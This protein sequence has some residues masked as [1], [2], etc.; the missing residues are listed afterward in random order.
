VRMEGPAYEMG[1]VQAHGVN[2]ETSWALSEM[3]KISDGVES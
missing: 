1:G 2:F 3:F